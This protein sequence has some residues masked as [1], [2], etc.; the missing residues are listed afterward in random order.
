[1]RWLPIDGS[2]VENRRNSKRIAARQRLNLHGA[3]NAETHEITVIE[4]DTVEANLLSAI[5]QKY[6]SASEILAILD[7]APYH[8]SKE[9]NTYYPDIGKFREA[10]IHFFRNFDQFNREVS[11][12]MS[13]EF[14]LA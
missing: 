14:E 2:S 6:P 5:E 9:I 1:M 10:C 3:I 8:H 13:G 12:L 4:S 11:R 7:N